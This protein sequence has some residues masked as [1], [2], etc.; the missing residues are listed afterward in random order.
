M[1]RRGLKRLGWITVLASASIA[2]GAGQVVAD[3][4]AARGDA[5]LQVEEGHCDKPRFHL[6]QGASEGTWQGETPGVSFVSHS[7][8]KVAVFEVAAGYRAAV[9]CVDTQHSASVTISP[10]GTVEGPKQI[11]LSSADDILFVGFSGRV[12]PLPPQPVTPTL[13]CVSPIGNGQ[14]RA[15]FGYQNPNGTAIEVAVGERNGFTPNPVN[16]DQPQVFPPGSPTN[17]FEVVFGGEMIT[18]TLTGRPVS[19]SSSS[20]PCPGVLRVDKLISP[21]DDPGQFQM[22]ID[23]AQLLRAQ[24]T[25]LIP[26]TGNTTVPP[27]D[28]RVSETAIAPTSLDD[29]DSSVVCRTAAGGG[30]VVAQGIGTSLTVPVRSGEHVVCVFLNSRKGGVEPPEPDADLAITKVVSQSLAQLGQTVTWTVTLRNKGPATATNVRIEDTLPEGVKYIEGSLSVPQGVTCVSSVCTLASLAAGA[31]VVGTFRTTATQVGSQVNLVAAKADERDPTPADNA[32]SAELTVEGTNV[33][34]VEPLLECV[35]ELPNGRRRA[36]FG[37]SNSGGSTDVIPLGDRNNFDPLPGDRGQPDQF[38]RGRVID[39]FQVDFAAGTHTWTLGSRRVAASAASPPCAATIRI[40]KALEPT[41]DLGRFN[42]EIDGSVSG[43]GANAGHQGTTGDVVVAALPPGS[44]HTVGERAVGNTNADD[45]ATTIVCRA[46]RGAGAELGASNIAS[47]AIRVAPGQEVVC[48]IRNV[49]TSPIPPTPTPPGPE[50]PVPPVP[51][52]IP[53]IPPIPPTPLPPEPPPAS[54]VDL[55]VTK[56]ASPL[57]I[58]I[59]STYTATVRVTNNGGVPATNVTVTELVSQGT[60]IVSAT[61]SQGT[62]IAL[63]RSCALGTL[64][65]GAS[66]TIA[67]VIRGQVV[68]SRVNV[69]EVDAAEAD[70]DRTDNVAS[71]LVHV[72]GPTQCG[73]LQLSRRTAT[74]GRRVTLAA[75]ARTV[76]GTPVWGLPMHL[77]GPG[78]ARAVTTNVDGVATFSF[79]PLLP[80]VIVARVPEATGASRAS[81]C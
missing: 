65:P 41:N 53:P 32:A 50:P 62:C 5:T 2:T 52:P 11:T 58:T 1:T 7:N 17:A 18:W 45:Y 26:T 76:R 13:S 68:G 59:G 49:R 27:G 48:T 57:S 29:Y 30:D 31:S 20:T 44:L 66:A 63:T 39:A 43:S 14:Y 33:E 77:R 69:V 80:G 16:R 47:L 54:Q 75:R 38:V 6:N 79:T 12:A 15:H 51:P 19:A 72:V 4:A 61:P 70:P 28:H 46:D 40:D 8:R 74:P 36:H 35:E 21:E 34:V 37:Y 9:T 71:A 10:E 56:V 73:Q 60:A 22:H 55:A 3:D 23:S 24:N 67:V 42:L 64:A 78:V 81:A 25:R